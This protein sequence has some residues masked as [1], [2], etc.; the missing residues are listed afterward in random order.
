MAF[1]LLGRTASAIEI[2]IQSAVDIAD[3]LI[4]FYVQIENGDS[5]IAVKT[6]ICLRNSSAILNLST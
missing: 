4:T 3:D 6:L 1:I 5:G 2:K